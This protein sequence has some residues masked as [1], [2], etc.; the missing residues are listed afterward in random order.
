MSTAIGQW[1]DTIL[2][3][4]S[5]PKSAVYGPREGEWAWH[6][7]GSI[8]MLL[9]GMMAVHPYRLWSGEGEGRG[10]ERERDY[11]CCAPLPVQI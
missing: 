8:C 7:S 3:V 9:V 5:G 1:R 2:R 10:G 4:M 6:L 11:L